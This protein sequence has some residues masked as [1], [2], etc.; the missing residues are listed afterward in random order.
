MHLGRNR[1]AKKTTHS[2]MGHSMTKI[3]VPTIV[4]PITLN[5]ALSKSPSIPPDPPTEKSYSLMSALT[6]R[7]RK[8]VLKNCR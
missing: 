4:F 2:I 1:S 7:R 5:Q 3:M 6:R 8:A